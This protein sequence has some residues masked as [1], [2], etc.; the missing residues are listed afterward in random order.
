[1]LEILVITIIVL[2]LLESREP[3]QAGND[4][5]CCGC[6]CLLPALIGG[7]LGLISCQP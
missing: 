7:A 4:G 1:M 6:G 5:G 2:W 3:R